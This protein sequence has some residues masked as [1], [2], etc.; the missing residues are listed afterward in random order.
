MKDLKIDFK[1]ENTLS[2]N[3]QDLIPVVI[4]DYRN[5]EVFMLGYTNK[6]ALEKTL[7]TGWVY[8]WSRNRKKLWMKGEESG[9]KF[10]VKEIFIDCD[11]DTLLIKIELI[12]TGGCHTGRRNCFYKKLSKKIL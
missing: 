11:F 1:K 3:G 6:E 12:G 8:F 7:K 2:V 9:N 5:G 4:Q 10:K